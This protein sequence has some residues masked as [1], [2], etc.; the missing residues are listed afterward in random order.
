MFWDIPNNKAVAFS[1]VKLWS[2]KYN[3]STI[4]GIK[5]KPKKIKMKFCAGPKRAERGE[6]ARPGPI[7]L[8]IKPDVDNRHQALKLSLPSLRALLSDPSLPTEFCHPLC[9]INHQ[10]ILYIHMQIRTYN[11]YEYIL[12]NVV[13][14]FES[15]YRGRDLQGLQSS[16]LRSRP[17]SHFRCARVAL[18]P[19]H[20]FDFS[21][22]P[23]NLLSFQMW[24]S[25][26]HNAIQV[27]SFPF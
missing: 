12:A 22:K 11:T 9:R 10:S 15:P 21:K 27:R 18:T 20:V 25:S 26:I 4:R 17:C 24:I 7:H 19:F 2:I 8:K 23:T 13:S 6:K 14:C 16:S 3:G 1:H 5:T